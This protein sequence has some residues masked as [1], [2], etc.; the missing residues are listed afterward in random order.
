[1]GSQGR[2]CGGDSEAKIRRTKGAREA[3][4]SG[5]GNVVGKRLLSR[6]F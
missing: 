4:I 5:K 3:K 2:L 6:I 1:M